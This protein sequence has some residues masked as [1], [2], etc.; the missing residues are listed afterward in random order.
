MI[1][2]PVLS[3]A[4]PV[5]SRQVMSSLPPR[6][7]AAN[8]TS[9]FSACVPVGPVPGLNIGSAPDGQVTLTWPGTA[10]GFALKQASSLTPPIPWTTV[11]N[12]PVLSNGQFTVTL[13]PDVG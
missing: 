3:L 5:R 4:S 6:L 1:A 9:E 13:A 7:T 2:T 10:T 12:V 11:T 8:N